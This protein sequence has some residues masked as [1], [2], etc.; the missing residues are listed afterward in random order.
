M[1][2]LRLLRRFYPLAAFLG[3]FVWDALT[4][5]Q[6]IRVIDF[7]RLGAFLFGAALL[8]LLLARREDAGTD[9]ARRTQLIA[10]DGGAVL[11][12]RH[13]TFCCNFS[14]AAFF[15]LSFILYFKSAGHIGTW[16]T[17]A[18][19]GSLLVANEFAGDRYGRRFTLTWALLSLNAILLFN[20]ALPHILGSLNPLWFYVSTATGVLLAHALRLIAPGCPG[21]ILPAWAMG[22]AL[23]I[24]WKLDMI[25][26]VP[27]VKRD[28]AIGQ[29]FIQEAGG[30]ALQVEQAP[31]WQF[32][33]DQA[34]TVH[35]PEGGRLYGISAIFA[36]LGV[37][38]TLEHRWEV[39]E[40]SGWR[41]AYRNRFQSS[42]GRER[43]FRGYSWVLNPQPGS[44][45]LIVATEDGRTIGVLPVTVERGE[46]LPEQIQQR[47]FN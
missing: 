15:R 5:G 43:G 44:W 23:L 37:K 19:L 10:G 13:L 18:F 16:L 3:G 28:L 31:S 17:A 30:Y 32:W 20:F 33:R 21:R 45:R 35:V 39:Y 14:L 29:A 38:A 7:W 24:A 8:I 46:A 6:R 11:R 12:G 2:N 25:A 22:A 41:I 40:S 4:L 27:L 42:G 26:P 34:A 47:L 1:D 9:F 36:P